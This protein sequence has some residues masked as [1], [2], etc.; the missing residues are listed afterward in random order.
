MTR[1][2]A[3]LA[4]IVCI[5]IAILCV[6]AA[7]GISGCRESG[8]GRSSEQVEEAPT[9]DLPPPPAATPPPSQTATPA[10]RPE[11]TALPSD[12]TTPIRPGHPESEEIV[13][14]TPTTT[15]TALGLEWSA[16]NL[17]QVDGLLLVDLT[18]PEVLPDGRVMAH[19]SPVDPR[20]IVTENGFDWELLPMPTGFRPGQY[21]FHYELW[22]DRWLIGDEDQIFFSDDLGANWTEV[23]LPTGITADQIDIPDLIDIS[24]DRWMIAGDEEAFY[25]DDQGAT[26]TKLRLALPSGPDEALR[27]ITR[28][29]W[30]GLVQV[31][32]ENMIAFVQTLTLPDAVALVVEAGLVP[33]R[34]SLEMAELEGEGV[35]FQRRGS[36][37][38]E[39]FELT[40]E[41]WEEI[42]DHTGQFLTTMFVTDGNTPFEPANPP[43]DD[44][45]GF[46]DV[47]VAWSSEDS[48]YLLRSKPDGS[49]LWTS[50]DGTS[51]KETP[52]S[53]LD[54][55]DPTGNPALEVA[56]AAMQNPYTNQVIDWPIS[57]H[58]EA[59]VTEE[60]DCVGNPRPSV[61]TAAGILHVTSVEVGPSGVFAEA[62][63]QFEPTFCIRITKGRHELRAVESGLF[64]Y[65]LA[66]WDREE[67][68]ALYEFGPEVMSPAQGE[69][70]D[71]IRLTVE[72][73]S[74]SE[75]PEFDPQEP[76]LDEPSRNGDTDS[77]VLTF[78][79]PA[80]GAELVTF[81]GEEIREALD[82]RHNPF[83]Y[84]PNV[85]E[86]WVGW[87]TN[88][89]DWAWQT[90]AD[91]FGRDYRYEDIS[92]EESAIGHGFVLVEVDHYPVMSRWFI[93]RVG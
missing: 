53:E 1:Y 60:P 48:F 61:K 67:D 5:A 89:T 70:P 21:E 40:E 27:S 10:P 59:S 4:R 12:S 9:D 33:D 74:E 19:A 80:T 6:L 64:S 62:T 45:L 32:G 76:A 39:R 73:H 38:L 13:E 92:I 58:Q 86:T 56:L 31:S 51:W 26:W 29:S 11:P 52:V 79:D 91:A 34:E 22:H 14:D 81:T 57:Q 68:I 82:A 54:L 23:P 50:H 24:G 42:V 65:Q 90:L 44:P 66:L 37:D 35:I 69:L 20:I 28:H 2:S 3:R 84:P 72:G 78:E 46:E 36:T 17:E 71:G 85:T 7:S 93:A 15:F 87:T 77:Y 41:R 83:I 8:N 75:K 55:R 63:H 47:Q 88:G 30:I 16:F 43:S 18:D 49:V 25:S